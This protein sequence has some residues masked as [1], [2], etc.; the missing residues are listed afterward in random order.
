M[1][2]YEIDAKMNYQETNI[3]AFVELQYIN[4]IPHALNFTYYYIMP[5]VYINAFI[6]LRKKLLKLGSAR[7][8]KTRSVSSIFSRIYI[9]DVPNSICKNSSCLRYVNIEFEIGPIIIPINKN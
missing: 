5:N 3:S 9:F 8:I 7:E 6:A 1:L 4:N 2:F